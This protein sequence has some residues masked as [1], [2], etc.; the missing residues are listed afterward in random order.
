M[1]LISLIF[2]WYVQKTKASNTNNMGISTEEIH[3]VLTNFGKLAL[4]DN[5]QYNSKKFNLGEEVNLIKMMFESLLDKMTFPIKMKSIGSEETY[6]VEYEIYRD[7]MTFESFL[8]VLYE[9]YDKR[10]RFGK[11]IAAYI[12]V[13]DLG[14]RVRNLWK[15]LIFVHF[16]VKELNQNDVKQTIYKLVNTKTNEKNDLLLD[17]IIRN[18]EYELLLDNIKHIYEIQGKNNNNSIVDK[19][20]DYKY[21]TMFMMSSIIMGFIVVIWG[22]NKILYY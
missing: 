1:L 13:Y 8:D 16:C 2:I 10:K 6:G 9:I 12:L 3:K 5:V 18:G 4:K 21:T 19:M 15:A 17:Q 20:L 11:E 22:L 7:D 14:N